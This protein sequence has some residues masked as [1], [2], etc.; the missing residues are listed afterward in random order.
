MRACLGPGNSA[1]PVANT[2]GIIAPPTDPWIARMTIMVSMLVANPQPML[3]RV[4][5]AA[6]AV[7]SQRVEKARDNTP[8]S[9]IMTI[10]AM[11]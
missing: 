2:V 3:A 5:P 11:R 4:N 8:E 6:D 9:G 10:S 1:K 7:K